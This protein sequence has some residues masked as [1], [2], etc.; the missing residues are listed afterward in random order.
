M[1]AW[2]LGACKVSDVFRICIRAGQYQKTQRRLRLPALHRPRERGQF[3]VAAANSRS[4]NTEEALPHGRRSCDPSC[5]Y[6]FVMCGP[7][8][9]KRQ[10]GMRLL[11][12][13]S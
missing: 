1:Q 7:S 6:P 9:T 3:Q 4:E 11:P 8:W 13:F 5:I 10:R 2:N 12:A